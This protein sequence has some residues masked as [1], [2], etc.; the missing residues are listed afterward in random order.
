MRDLKALP[1][2][3]ILGFLF[4]SN[5]VVARFGLGQFHPLTYNSIR[6]VIAS[7]GYLLLFLFSRQWN[8]PRDI[9]TWLHGSIWGIFGL[10]VSMCS[11]VISLQYL[12]AGITA[13]LIAASPI[14]TAVLAHFLLPGERLN[15]RTTLGVFL[16]FA[17]TGIILLTGENGLSQF[18]AADWRGYAWV[19]LGDMAVAGGYVYGR[20][21]LR[22][23][24][25]VGV[26][27]VR[28]VSAAL[29]VA[30]VVSLFVG[31]DLSRVRLSGYMA[32]AYSGVIA[33]FFPFL[34]EVI[35]VKK[36]GAVAANQ[37]AYVQPVVAA[38]LGALFLDEKITIILVTGMIVIFM[39]LK[40]LN[41]RSP[42]M[43]KPDER[44][45][46]ESS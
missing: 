6:L 4:G 17:G 33:T 3:L 10:A 31:Y 44:R 27:A 13:L 30:L 24:S 8:W 23:G 34:I 26:A 28:M 16:G 42:K 25:A 5:L 36:Y 46:N 11:F 22:S 12:S 20:H 21:F 2:I 39:A 15:P 14:M 9:H 37:S 29:A 7:L 1:L 18:S 43:L 41:D 38:V 19:L 45:T 35:L 40:L 32:L